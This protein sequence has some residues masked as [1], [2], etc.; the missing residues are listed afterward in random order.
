MLAFDVLRIQ[1][2]HGHYAKNNPPW[3]VRSLLALHAVVPFDESCLCERVDQ[4]SKRR[5]E[6]H[7]TKS[8]SETPLLVNFII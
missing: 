4:R 7:V 8:Q 3:V 6:L 5:N 2:A 1:F